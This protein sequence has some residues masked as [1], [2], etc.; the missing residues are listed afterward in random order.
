L[1]CGNYTTLTRR[2]HKKKAKFYL[3]TLGLEQNLVRKEDFTSQLFFFS[4]RSH[5]FAHYPGK[6]LLIHAEKNSAREK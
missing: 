5:L 6:F 4:P 3:S 2:E 1:P